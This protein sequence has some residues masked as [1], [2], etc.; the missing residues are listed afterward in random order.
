MSL[1]SAQQV[2]E[3]VQQYDKPSRIFAI[4]SCSIGY[5]VAFVTNFSFYICR[6][7]AH[8]ST[9]EQSARS[10]LSACRT[11]MQCAENSAQILSTQSCGSMTTSKAISSCCPFGFCLPFVPS[12]TLTCDCSTTRSL[13][14]YCGSFNLYATAT[15]LA[16]QVSL[17]CFM[18]VRAC[19]LDEQQ[20]DTR[21]QDLLA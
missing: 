19:M 4:Y 3:I 2:I 11:P 12:T 7:S 1:P 15:R 20:I 6:R 21:Y 13:Q 14:R 9:T 17:A 16:K 10:V 18:R 5:V 8:F